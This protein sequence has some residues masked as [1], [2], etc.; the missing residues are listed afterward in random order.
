VSF[1]SFRPDLITSRIQLVSA[2]PRLAKRGKLPHRIHAPNLI[3]HG[4]KPFAETVGGIKYADLGLL[5][6][7]E[8][9]DRSTEENS[10]QEAVLEG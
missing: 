4:E 10:L 6:F 9:P 1:S 7:R 5:P 2:T 3:D 8:V